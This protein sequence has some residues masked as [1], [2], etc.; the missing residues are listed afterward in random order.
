M[1]TKPPSTDELLQRIVEVQTKR[2]ANWL[3]QS[4]PISRFLEDMHQ[5]EI[6]HLQQ[7]IAANLSPQPV[8]ATPPAIGWRDTLS[9]MIRQFLS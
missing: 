2:R 9:R 3:M 4:A 7:Q 8:A 5:A 1:N 6:A